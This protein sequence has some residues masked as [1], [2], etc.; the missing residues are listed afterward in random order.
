MGHRPLSRSR[1]VLERQPRALVRKAIESAV[2]HRLTDLS[3]DQRLPHALTRWLGWVWPL[4]I[5]FIRHGPRVAE[6]RDRQADA[7]R[8]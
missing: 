5:A 3:L 1:I 7:T 8:R 4:R 2:L 6:T